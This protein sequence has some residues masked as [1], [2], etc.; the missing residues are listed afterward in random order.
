MYNADKP[1]RDELP[2]TKQL[3]R[4][5]FIAL[6]AAVVILVTIVLPSEYG[7]DPTRIGSVLG[8][9]EMGEIK[10]ELAEEAE[11]DD[12]SRLGSEGRHDFLSVLTGLF[13]TAAQAQD[14]S[15]PW[16]DEF[17]FTLAPG[18]GLDLKLV[19]KEGAIAEYSWVAEGG[20]INFDLHAHGNGLSKTYVKGRGEE[21]GEGSFTAAFDG[22]HGWFWRNRDRQDVTIMIKIRGDYSELKRGV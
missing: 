1:N 16:T 4:S 22:E 5:T 20:R 15:G 8:L 19:M 6:A 14:S 12:H 3:L 21:T 7:I 2:S 9:T 17:S 13:V 10:Q 18:D 11:R